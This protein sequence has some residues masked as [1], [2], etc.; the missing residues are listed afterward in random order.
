MIQSKARAQWIPTVVRYLPARVSGMARHSSNNFDTIRVVAAL[1]VLVSHSFPLSYG[2]GS[3]QPLET[4]SHGQ[5]QFGSVALLVFFVISGYLITQSF[6]RKPEAVGFL[7]ARALRIFPGLFLALVL[8]AF[9]LGPVM[10][11]L[12]LGRYLGHL[13]TASY[14]PVNLTLVLA[15]YPLPGVF[16]S[17]PGGEAA[18]ASLWTLKYEFAMYGLVLALGVAGLLRRGAVSVLWLAVITASL[19][20]IR[21]N[22]VH[23]AI[24]FLG[25]A[26]FYVWRDR[27]ILSRGLAMISA[28]V[29][30]A[31][32]LLD[33][34]HLAFAAFGTYLVLYL[35]L[36]PVVHLPK[37]ARK[38]DLSYGIYIFAW[39]VQQVATHLLGASVT[40][41]WN[42]LLSLPVVLG[43]AWLSWHLIEKPALALKR[44]TGATAPD[45][46]RSPPFHANIRD[47]LPVA[48]QGTQSWL[49]PAIE[50][51]PSFHHSPFV[52]V[53]VPQDA[54][55]KRISYGDGP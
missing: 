12:P 1:A 24:P 4:V 31:S 48:G 26:A 25:G 44:P 3:P 52:S 23:F 39:P 45:G 36:S 10:T 51:D 41:Y 37:L 38:G 21:Y 19:G 55:A 14:V 2:S 18:N 17:N 27:V 32:L 11:V 5:T 15:Q 34:F 30:S 20:P 28:A 16:T 13:G 46:S 29:L 9:V 54:A 33:G 49:G 47:A 8:T 35:A 42:T 50:P 43:L 22:L 7:R 6:D 40:W 53:V